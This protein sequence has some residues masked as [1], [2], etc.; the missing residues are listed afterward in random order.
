VRGRGGH[1]PYLTY[2]AIGA[3]TIYKKIEM[4]EKLRNLVH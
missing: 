2:I 1:T 3:E 4:L